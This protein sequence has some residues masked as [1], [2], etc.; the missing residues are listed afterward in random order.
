MFN[1]ATT[2]DLLGAASL[3]RNDHTHDVTKQ[4]ADSIA[5]VF[6]LVGLDR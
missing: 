6:A 3:V 1:S 2:L 5:E 4:L